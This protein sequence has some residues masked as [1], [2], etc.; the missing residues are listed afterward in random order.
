MALQPLFL[1]QGSPGARTLHPSGDTK[2][3]HQVGGD[4][5]KKKPK[6]SWADFN[7]IAPGPP[8][9]AFAALLNAFLNKQVNAYANPRQNAITGYTKELAGALG[10]IAPQIGQAYGQAFNQGSALENALANRLTGQGQATA[11]DL[12]QAL[13][14]AG[15]STAPGAAAAQTAVG[16]GNASFAQGSAGLQ[17]MLARGAAAQA[18]GAKLPG[19]AALS[20]LQATKGL[21]AQ[22]LSQIPDLRNQFLSNE[23][24]KWIAKTQFG[25]SRAQLRLS[26]KQERNRHN[27]F[28]QSLALD[29]KKFIA[30]QFTNAA[31]TKSEQHK[32]KL[33]A[34]DSS[35]NDAITKAE[36]W[37][38]GSGSGSGSGDPM[39]GGGGAGSVPVREAFNR[40]LARLRHELRHYGVS[41]AK[42]RR[43]AV[44]VLKQAGYT[45]P[46]SFN[47][48]PSGH[49]GGQGPGQAPGD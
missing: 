30:D 33:E 42:L 32:A 24:Q 31:Q 12:T 6:A 19:I 44:Y 35:I 4:K 48:G 26:R 13:A 2:G 1:S 34:I 38:K 14:N 29:N 41:D 16:V 11:S 28:L 3:K 49:V 7:P 9:G 22:A 45:I 20:G 17:E 21:Q 25:T 47:T 43:S 8:H 36:G 37:R 27:E 23:L 10:G 46:S 40:V 39:A 5:R 15:Q 18:Y